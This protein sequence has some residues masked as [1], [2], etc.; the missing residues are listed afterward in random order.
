MTCYQ[1]T[2]VAQLARIPRTSLSGAVFDQILDRIVDGTFPA[3]EPLPSERL[4]CTELGVSRT[5]VREAL[6]RLAQLRL[7]QVRHG[8]ETTVLDFR[9][10]AGLDLL[11]RL[12]ARPGRGLH[13]EAS[14][15]G[16]EMRA[17]LAPEVARLAALRGGAPLARKLEIHLTAMAGSTDDLMALHHL[18][19]AFWSEV[20]AGA[21][22]L[23]Y[24]LAFNSLRDA[25]AHL[26]ERAAAAMTDELRDLR[27]YRAIAE[28]IRRGDGDAA[29]RA[30]RAHL[31]LGAAGLAA[32]GSR[33]KR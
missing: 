1:I 4:L 14:R 3:G 24:Q 13:A 20:I 22:N 29:A 19:F 32:L 10:V 5:A 33:R 2:S 7:I 6:A 16:I 30:A 15:A 27:G 31:A 26:R 25:F 21:D 12:L 23:A 18:S 9:A 11:P 28:A 17:A 8:G